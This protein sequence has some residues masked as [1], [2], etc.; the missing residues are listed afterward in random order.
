MSDKSPT[1]W[2][3][4][5]LSQSDNIVAIDLKKKDGT[6]PFHASF[7]P[8]EHCIVLNRRT[9]S[10]WQK[11]I[12]LAFESTASV[13]VC[14]L[15]LLIDGKIVVQ[16]QECRFVWETIQAEDLTGARGQCTSGSSIVRPI[17]TLTP[18]LVADLSAVAA[19]NKPGETQVRWAIDNAMEAVNALLGHA[20]LAEKR[21]D[22]RIT[23]P[24]PPL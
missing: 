11:E 15:L 5:I 19:E 20:A 13:N 9:E 4:S 3:F 7:R 10:G 18:S 8:S 24:A 21:S 23:L 22:M 2:F 16:I 1:G 6:I 14:V 17:Y 12:R